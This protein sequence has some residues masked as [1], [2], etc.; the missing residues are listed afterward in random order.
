MTV[1]RMETVVTMNSIIAL[2][3]IVGAFV[4]FAG[5]LLYGDLTWRGRF[6]HNRDR[7]G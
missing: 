6:P 2:S 4:G 3:A 5:F 1:N 7:Q